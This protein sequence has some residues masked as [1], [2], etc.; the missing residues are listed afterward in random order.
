MEKPE[1]EIEVSIGPVADLGEKIPGAE[2]E[3]IIKSMQGAEHKQLKKM[4]EIISILKP[5][6]LENQCL[7][8][9]LGQ[10]SAWQEAKEELRTEPKRYNYVQKS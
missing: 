4:Q 2:A 10:L 3:N 6:E 1:D 9:I 5:E 7:K 8:Q